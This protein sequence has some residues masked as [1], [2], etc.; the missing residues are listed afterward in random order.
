MTH[1]NFSP[2]FTIRRSSLAVLITGL[3]SA[4]LFYSVPAQAKSADTINVKID[5]TELLSERGTKR[6][7][8]RLKKAAET[9]CNAN[10][11]PV[12]ITQR[13][14]ADRCTANLMESFVRQLKND[15][16]AAMHDTASYELG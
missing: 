14:A 9:A 5:R 13:V 7:Y 8:Y 10:E 6:T 2:S 1:L 12:S 16:L 11:G 3:L 15:K 4:S